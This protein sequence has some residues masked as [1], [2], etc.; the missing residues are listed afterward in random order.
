VIWRFSIQF[1]NSSS[2]P[3][4]PGGSMFSGAKSEVCGGLL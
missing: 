3:A 2:R 4:M 1:W